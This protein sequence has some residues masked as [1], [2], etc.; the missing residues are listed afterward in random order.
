[1]PRYINDGYTKVTWVPG[2]GTIADITSPTLAEL[3]AGEDLECHLTKDGLNITF[4]ENA[5]EDGA[6]CEVF[7]A[8]G[9]GT[10]GV[11]IELTLKRR[12]TV[13]GDTDAAWALFHHGDVGF[14]VVRRGV[15]LAVTPD[16]ETGDAVEVYAVQSGNKRPAPTATNEQ[17]KFMTSFYATTTPELD[18]VVAAS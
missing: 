15:E 11:S 18:G 8:Q 16:Y 5:F 2:A 17:A 14:L 12:N 4:A 6:L 13:G 7:D 10:F 3:A 9:A 1:M